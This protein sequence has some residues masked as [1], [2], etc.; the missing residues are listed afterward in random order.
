LFPVWNLFPALAASIL[1]LR[2]KPLGREFRPLFL[3]AHVASG[4]ARKSASPY[5]V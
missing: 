1:S 3:R 5:F 4:S 2:S